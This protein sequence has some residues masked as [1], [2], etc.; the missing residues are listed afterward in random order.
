M[1]TDVKPIQTYYCPAC[2]E[3]MIY[4]KRITFS[5]SFKNYSLNPIK[6]NYVLYCPFCG[7][8]EDE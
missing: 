7:Y 3:S 1:K 8:S 6:V 2:S 4:S 5:L